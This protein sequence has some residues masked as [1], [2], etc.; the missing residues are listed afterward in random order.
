MGVGGGVQHAVP[1]L[2]LG[3]GGRSGGR[4][5]GLGVSS[6]DDDHDGV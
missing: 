1:E 6:D 5:D 2:R 4:V 3:D